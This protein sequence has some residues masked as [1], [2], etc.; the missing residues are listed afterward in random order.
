M[1]I[2]DTYSYADA[3]TYFS[4]CLAEGCTAAEQCLRYQA[5][6]ALMESERQLW[7]LSPMRI[8]PADGERCPCF[9]SI[10]PIRVVRGFKRALGSVRADKVKTAAAALMGL[11]SRRTYYRM[12]NGEI[13]LNAD[14]QQKVAD[15]L[16]KYGAEQP[17]VFD[18]YDEVA[19][20]QG[21]Q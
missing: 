1:D 9:L 12:L 14:E 16:T 17:I 3:P 11:H 10:K 2:P 21:I 15:I 19:P 8:R 7:V 4:K 13:A 18:A 6:R 20:W 5:A